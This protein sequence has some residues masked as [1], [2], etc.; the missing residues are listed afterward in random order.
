MGWR[1]EP[2]VE[3]VVERSEADEK[4]IVA[5]ALAARPPFDGR[6][7]A[8]V[9]PGFARFRTDEP[10]APIDKIRRFQH[11]NYTLRVVAHARG[12]ER[13]VGNDEQ[14]VGN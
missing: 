7:S 11:A 5:S 2:T 13:T 14:A 3:R 1:H 12:D 9:A 8:G 10:K 4:G 6:V